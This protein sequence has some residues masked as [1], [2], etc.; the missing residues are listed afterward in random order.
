MNKP[1]PEEQELKRFGREFN[2]N[3]IDSVNSSQPD[4][5]SIM[6]MEE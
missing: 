3:P 6:R 2:R 1:E 4:K 5:E